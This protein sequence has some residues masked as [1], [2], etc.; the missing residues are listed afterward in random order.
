MT[1]KYS[2]MALTPFSWRM[3]RGVEMVKMMYFLVTVVDSTSETSHS[4]S[5]ST[6]KGRAMLERSEI[7][8]DGE[9]L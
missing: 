9:Q 8:D 7:D 5:N 2:I 1:R 3:L 6:G 4:A